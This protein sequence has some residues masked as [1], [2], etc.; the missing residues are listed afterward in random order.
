MSNNKF[1]SIVQGILAFLV[2][3]CLFAV[4]RDDE[5]ISDTMVFLSVIRNEITALIG[6]VVLGFGIIFLEMKKDK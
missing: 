6:I 1:I 5:T 3:V 2:L 4:V